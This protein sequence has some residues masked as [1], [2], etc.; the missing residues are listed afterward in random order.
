MWNA[1][2]TSSGCST[3]WLISVCTVY[4]GLSVRKFGTNTVDQLTHRDCKSDIKLHSEA[5]NDSQTSGKQYIPR[6][7]VANGI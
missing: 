5:N 2:Q 4:A 1:V 3:R 6:S 7:D